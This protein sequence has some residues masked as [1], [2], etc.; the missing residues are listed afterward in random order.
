MATLWN[1][2]ALTLPALRAPRPQAQFDTF[3]SGLEAR[4]LVW[5]REEAHPHPDDLGILGRRGDYEGGFSML[6]VRWG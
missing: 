2:R 5:E 6:S 1:R 3:L 4:G